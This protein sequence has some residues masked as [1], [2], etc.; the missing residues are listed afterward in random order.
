MTLAEQLIEQV[1]G[2]AREIPDNLK[3]IEKFGRPSFRSGGKAVEIDVSS[4][5]V[6]AVKKAAK[7]KGFKG[8]IKVEPFD[9]PKIKKTRVVF[10]LTGKNES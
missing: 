4:D 6:D 9:N 5:D 2:E 7:S 1:I 8:R 10:V 3:S